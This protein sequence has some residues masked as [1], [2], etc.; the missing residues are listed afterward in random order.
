ML[1]HTA[2]VNMVSFARFIISNEGLTFYVIQS[3]E[4]VKSLKF[5]DELHANSNWG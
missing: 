1:I 3:E 2:L 5:T 4:L